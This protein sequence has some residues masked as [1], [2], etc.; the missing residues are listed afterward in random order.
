MRTPE[1][2]K[3]LNVVINKTEKFTK[4][5][6]NRSRRPNDIDFKLGELSCHSSIVL[7]IVEHMNELVHW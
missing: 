2:T 1:L 6:P 7:S 5:E 3:Y 4:F